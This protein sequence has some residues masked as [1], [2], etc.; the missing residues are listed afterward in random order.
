MRGRGIAAF[1]IVFVGLGVGSLAL[2]ARAD[3]AAEL[4]ALKAE[5]AAERTALKQ[6]REGLA[7]QR[8]RI[9]DAIADLEDTQ[10]AQRAA[11]AGAPA[12]GAASTELSGPRLE[13]Y[14]FVQL[15]G[16][17][18][19]DRIE[20]GLE[21][22]A[23]AVEDPGQLPR[24]RRLRQRRRDRSSASSSRVSASAASCPR[25]L[26]EL[27]TIFE[28]ELFGIGV[29]EGQTTIRLRHA[30]GELGQIGAGQT[31]VSSWT[32]TCSPTRSSTGA[33]RDGVLPQPPGALD[34]VGQREL[35]GGDRDRVA[36]RGLR[37]GQG[38][39]RGPRARAAELEQLPGP[40]RPAPLRGE[41]GHV[42]LAAILRGLGVQG[43]SPPT[44][45]SER[46]RV[47]GARARL[48][49]EPGQRVQ[50]G[51]LTPALEGD[52]ILVQVAYGHGI[53]NYMNDGG[54]D[55]A[56][57][58]E[59]PG[60]PGEDDPDARLADL[61][62]P[63]VERALDQLDRLQRAPPVTR[64]SGQ[65]DDAF[66]VGQYASTSTCSTIRLP[67]MLVGPE[68]IWGGRENKDGSN[69][70]DRH[71]RPGLASSTTSTATIFGGAR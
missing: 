36:R 38:R 20:S 42:Q 58:D 59:P 47:P 43:T 2:P 14:G 9:D 70:G 17:Y 12:V 3:D 71:A 61:L 41:W 11:A 16:I 57:E 15:D 25:E 6:E 23:A 65:T 64:S 53:A 7:D 27:R 22:G 63:L 62:Q 35:D 30:W 56:P 52:Q 29:D 19:F 21:R 46:A 5:I 24:R 67:D 37:P 28:F 39:A 10:A 50:H 68:L 54:N 69:R 55:I 33:R 66:K 26:G 8:R 60:R 32:P 1:A 49:R 44:P 13:V 51:W 40:H 34:A 18:D 48:G 4:R 31:A 45:S